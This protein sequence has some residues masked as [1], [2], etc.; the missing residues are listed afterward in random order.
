MC[1]VLARDAAMAPVCPAL[2]PDTWFAWQVILIA[3]AGRFAVA[4]PQGRPAGGA[5]GGDEP[6][7]SPPV[8]E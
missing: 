5:F 2:R 1:T 8:G 7:H 4:R 6:E 3:A